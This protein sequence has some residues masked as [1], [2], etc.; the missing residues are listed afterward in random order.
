MPPYLQAAK[1]NHAAAFLELQIGAG[2]RREPLEWLPFTASLGD[3]AAMYKLG[4]I[5]LHG[6]EIESAEFE[7]AEKKST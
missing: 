1:Q 5:L 4:M 6:F 3:T 2:T 7:M